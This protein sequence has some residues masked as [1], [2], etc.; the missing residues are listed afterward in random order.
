MN[1]A[2][3]VLINALYTG[4]KGTVVLTSLPS[5]V[6]DILMDIDD[7]LF[8]PQED[9]SMFGPSLKIVVPNNS[10]CA[11]LNKGDRLRL[12]FDTFICSATD[13]NI[14][15]TP[16]KPIISIPPKSALQSRAERLNTLLNR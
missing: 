16:I 5:S 14:F 7:S 15:I 10:P 9:G 12:E 1:Y 6:A 13:D 11:E 2:A 4:K 8:I 3:T